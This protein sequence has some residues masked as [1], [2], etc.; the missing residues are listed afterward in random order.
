MIPLFYLTLLQQ[1]VYYKIVP[2]NISTTVRPLSYPNTNVF[3]LCFSIVSRTS[4]KNI[5]EKWLPE[6]KHHE[7]RAHL[8]LVGTKAD[9]KEDT[10]L[11]NKLAKEGKSMVDI[12][13]ATS[14]ANKIGASKYM[15]TKVVHF[16]FA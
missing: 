2:V 11:L 7:G 15:G 8:I 9:M 16:N 3:L 1:D 10:Q 14:Y 13:E 12:K 6:V 4:F 5:A